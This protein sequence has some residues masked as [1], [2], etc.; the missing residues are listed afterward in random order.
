VVT[1]S[2]DQADAP[3]S[4]ELRPLIVNTRKNR[5]Y[6]SRAAVYV[7]RVLVLA[8]VLLLWQYLPSI[9]SV[10]HISQF[11]DPYFISS[12]TMVATELKEMMTGANGTVVI[13]SYIWPTVEASIF[14]TAI[15]MACGAA[16]GLVLSNFPTLGQVFRPFLVALNAIPRVAL[17][18]IVVLLFGST[19]KSNIVVA[20][21]VVFFIAFFNAFEGGRGV[22]R[23]IIDNAALLGARSWATLRHIRLPYVLA[24]TMSSL[25]LG[26]TFA[27]MT[28]VTTEIL[29][30][31]PGLGRLISI[32][33]QTGDST[34]TFAVVIVLAIVGWLVV[35][36]ADLLTRR[37]LHWWNSGS[38]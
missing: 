20:S 7:Y 27:I 14:G 3:V 36:I 34:L 35:S 9:K 13:W 29:T 11:L 12:P 18:P 8:G 6:N 30:G 15:G 10:R 25:P 2:H 33:G 38:K 26:L 17:I 31:Y 5:W 37:V 22:E 4:S 1:I 32:A 16:C 21:L 19:L 23:V 24:C 28:V